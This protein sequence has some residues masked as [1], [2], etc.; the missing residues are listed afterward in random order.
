MQL[1][2]IT[3]PVLL[4]KK[5]KKFRESLPFWIFVMHLTK[6]RPNLWLITPKRCQK[7]LCMIHHYK[8]EYLPVRLRKYQ[9]DKFL[10]KISLQF[11]EHAYFQ[12]ETLN[13]R[14]SFT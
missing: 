12:L 3:V 4:K 14:R 9:L 13:Q 7:F 2:E 1:F 10:E 11:K 5:K 6:F 8:A